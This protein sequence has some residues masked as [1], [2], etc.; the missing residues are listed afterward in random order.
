M[1]SSSESDEGIDLVHYFVLSLFGLTIVHAVLTRT[2]DDFL[3]YP[4][5]IG[6]PILLFGS[7]AQLFRA[8]RSGNLKL[9]WPHLMRALI[10]G[11]LIGYGI[12]AFY[13]A[14]GVALKD[15]Y[16]YLNSPS[17]GTNLTIALTIALTLFISI[18]LFIF[19]LKARALYGLTEVVVGVTVAV[20]RVT[21]NPDG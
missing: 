4:L 2:P 12:G 17:S 10:G 11:P 18:G 20:Y 15:A 9:S 21:T 16:I 8:Y 6:A 1:S 14:I 13:Y 19:R 7:G 5:Y 3:T